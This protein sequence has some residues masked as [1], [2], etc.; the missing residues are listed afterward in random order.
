M[1]RFSGAEFLDLGFR[2][3]DEPAPSQRRFTLIIRNGFRIFK[4]HGARPF[5]SCSCEQDQFRTRAEL[6]DPK[7]PFTGHRGSLVVLDEL[8][9][10][11]SL[12]P[13]CYRSYDRG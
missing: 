4:V 5:I 6:E 7:W 9:W 13:V 11:P 10:Q 1:Y 12:F 2:R 3:D 8:H